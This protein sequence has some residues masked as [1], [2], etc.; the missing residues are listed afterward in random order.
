MASEAPRSSIPANRGRSQ[1]RIVPLSP[2]AVSAALTF[3]K[4]RID[5]KSVTISIPHDEREREEVE[6][7][8][9]HEGEQAARAGGPVRGDGQQLDGEMG[10]DD[11]DDR[12]EVLVELSGEHECGHEADDQRMQE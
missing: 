1:R 11:H 3:S 7:L 8:I 6:R 9:E 2:S 4:T 10:D 5:P 12:D